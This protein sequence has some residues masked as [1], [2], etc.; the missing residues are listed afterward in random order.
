MIGG[1]CVIVGGVRIGHNSI[2]AAGS[3]LIKDV[4]ENTIFAGNPAKK[5]KDIEPERIEI[6]ATAPTQKI[7]VQTLRQV[8]CS[9]QFRLG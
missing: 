1:H 9:Y 8:S 5:F 3:V 6:T 7:S 4:P 2:I